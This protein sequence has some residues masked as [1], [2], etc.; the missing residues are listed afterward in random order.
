VSGLSAARIK[1]NRQCSYVR[2][3]VL[4]PLLSTKDMDA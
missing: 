3:A 1:M 4:I 2:C